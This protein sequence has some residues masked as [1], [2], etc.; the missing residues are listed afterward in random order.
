VAPLIV[1]LDA[2]ILFSASLG[3]PAFKLLWQL[4]RAGR[5]RLVTS[6]HCRVEAEENLKRT[7]PDAALDRFWRILDQV[8]GAAD[9]LPGQIEQASRRLPEKDAPVFASAVAAGS[10]VLLTGDVRHFGRLMGRR[11]LS[12]RVRTIR[13]FLLEG[14]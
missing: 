14:P 10:D 9:P 4:E 8:G 3:G 5:V 2:N 12:P 1:F 11:D 7:R 6:R 13:A